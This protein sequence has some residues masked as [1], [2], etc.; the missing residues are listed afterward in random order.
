VAWDGCTLTA[1]PLREAVELATKSEGANLELES[2]RTEVAQLREIVAALVNLVVE[3]QGSE[4]SM[5]DMDDEGYLPEVG[6]GSK[7]GWGM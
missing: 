6:T 1:V 5:G 2:L 3:N 4:D 7:F